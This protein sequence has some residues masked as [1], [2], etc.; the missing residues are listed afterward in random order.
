M[1]F[2]NVPLLGINRTYK[3]FAHHSCVLDI[4]L[5]TICPY[6]EQVQYIENY[7]ASVGDDLDA[8]MNKFIHIK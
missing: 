3:M 8:K 1:H 6:S 4:P 7:G 2:S 5:M